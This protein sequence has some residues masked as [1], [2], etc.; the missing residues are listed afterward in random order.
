MYAQAEALFRQR[1]ET[2]RRLLGPERPDTLSAL[3]DFAFMYQQQGKYALAETYAAQALAGRRHAL[4]AEHRDT[5]AS[6]AG[7]ALAYVS[8]GKFVESEPLAHKAMEMDQK[9]Q[10]DDWQRFRAES[11]LGESLAGEKRNTPKPN[12]CCWKAIRGCWRGRTASVRP[13]ATIWNWPISGLCSFT[14]PGAIP[15]KPPNGARSKI[16]L[17]HP[18][19]RCGFGRRILD[20]SGD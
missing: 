12:R 6:A 7:L 15:T 3:S 10:P 9:K 8:Q 17:L 11:L 4:G 19:E 13:I 1:L 16:T 20:Q 14:G 2:E 18:A 5:M